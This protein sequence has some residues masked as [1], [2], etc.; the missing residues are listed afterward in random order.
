V[1]S[2]WDLPDDLELGPD[3]AAAL[4]ALLHPSPPCAAALPID[5]YR[6]R[7]WCEAFEESDPIHH[8]VEAARAR[9]YGGLVA[10]S[11]AL[12]TTFLNDFRWPPPAASTRMPRHVHFAVKEILGYPVAIVTSVDS[13]ILAP[14]VVGDRIAFRQRLVSISQ[15]KQTRL[16]TGHFWVTE[17]EYE[18]QGGSVLRRERMTAFGYGERRRGSPG[19][20]ERVPIEDAIGVM[21]N[22]A[23]DAGRRYWDDVQ[24]GDELPTLRIPLTPLR[25]AY[26]V[27]ATRDFAPQHTDSAYA[28]EHAGIDGAFLGSR[29]QQGMVE[30]YLEEWG[31]PACRIE[32]VSL[33]MDQPIRIEGDLQIGGRVIEVGAEGAIV[34]EIELQAGGRVASRA[35]AHVQEARAA[36]IA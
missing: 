17:R 6:I 24:V 31:G 18:K 34:V 30:R 29:F 36:G 32:R 5:E 23:R 7:H 16:G 10:P 25:A 28:R 1:S 20:S 26:V 12:T 14:A 2:N 9:G 8:D 35:R 11:A 22:A 13:E 21:G 33:R 4:A 27:S 3:D 15:R 19:G